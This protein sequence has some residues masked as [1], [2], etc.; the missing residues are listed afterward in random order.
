MK[1]VAP[2]PES[3]ALRLES[4]DFIDGD[5]DVTPGVVDS[6]VRS[7]DATHGVADSLGEVDD[8]YAGVAGSLSEVG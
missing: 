5:S 6:L 4:G 1:T 3:P 8:R 7:N 2:W